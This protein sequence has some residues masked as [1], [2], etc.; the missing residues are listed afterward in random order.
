LDVLVL[1]S[2]DP[3]NPYLGGGEQVVAVFARALIDAGH[4]VRMVCARFPSSRVHE[5]V[6][7]MQID[8]V[9][10]EKLLGPAAWLAYERRFR[11][12][13][14]LVL[15]EV[16]GG[17]RIPF[18]AP[19]YV[20]KPIIAVWHQD[21]LPIFEQQYGRVYMPAFSALERILLLVHSRSSF[22]V[23]SRKSRDDLIGKGADPRLIRVFHPG[24]PR[25]LLQS[26]APP[27]SESREPRVVCLGKMRRYKSCHH[28]LFVLA[29]LIP[30]V[31]GVRLSVIG[32][33]DDPGYLAELRG[34]AKKLRVE[35]K[36]EFLVNA[37]EVQ[38]VERLRTS[39]A[40]LAPAPVEGFGIAIAEANA[41]G[42]PA[43]GTEGVPLDTLQD[44]RNGFRV[45]FMGFAE[46]TDRTAR[47]LTDNDLFDRMSA[48]S[49]NFAQQFTIA[50]SVQPLLRLVAEMDVHR[51]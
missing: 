10:G 42:L 30:I 22:L 3:A 40:L 43:V 1:V 50:N 32:R 18:F 4:R 16:I 51:S 29:A 5:D 23:P 45:P 17:A 26:D 25:T 48:E 11:R 35:D 7:G 39:R 47:L 49:R 31:P 27:K 19:L 44:G 41:C 36:V 13:T 21:H 6:D 9:A 33:S 20:N 24:L 2:R 12:Q 38:K 34:I 14:D 28:A 46:M 8:R 15:T 37:S